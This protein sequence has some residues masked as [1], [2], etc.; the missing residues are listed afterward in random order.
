MRSTKSDHDHRSE[1]TANAALLAIMLIITSGAV[2]HLQATS[3]RSSTFTT[4]ESM[5]QR[6]NPT[7]QDR[8]LCSEVSLSVEA[9][10]TSATRPDGTH[11][12]MAHEGRARALDRARR[13]LPPPHRV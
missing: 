2:L 8:L 3:T 10:T 7:A 1:Q 11:D 6:A 4:R 9:E 13:N 5:M 12:T